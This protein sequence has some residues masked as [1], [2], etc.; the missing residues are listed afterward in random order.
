MTGLNFTGS[1]TPSSDGKRSAPG[2]LFGSIL[3]IIGVG[4]AAVGADE[5]RRVAPALSWPTSAGRV[6]SARITTDT[7]ATR[8]GRY[9]KY[10][11]VTRRFHVAYRFTVDGS[12][13][14]G[15]RVDLLPPNRRDARA[16]S[17]TY[18]RGAAV[19]V[20]YRTERAEESVLEV[21]F[22]ARAVLTLLFGATLVATGLRLS[23]RRRKGAA[24]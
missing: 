17:A 7:V 24:A 15:N 6:D 9:R 21:K 2:R 4:L 5:I 22:P 19:R 3:V 20:H 14:R 16:D 10:P 12:E 11:V 18:R 13:Y 1:I 23:R 8:V